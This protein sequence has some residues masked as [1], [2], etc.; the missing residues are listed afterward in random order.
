MPFRVLPFD[1]FEEEAVGTLLQAHDGRRMI[2][3][4]KLAVGTLARLEL[5]RRLL[6]AVGV[7]DVL[8]EVEEEPVVLGLVLAEAA[9]GLTKGRCLYDVRTGKGR[10]LTKK[11]KKK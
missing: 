3:D 5:Q 9:L 2:G 1:V 4:H 7:V 10:W 6:L 11:K 8:G